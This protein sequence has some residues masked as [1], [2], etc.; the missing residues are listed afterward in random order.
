MYN[1]LTAVRALNDIAFVPKLGV[2]SI[3]GYTQQVFAY[4]AALEVL[5]TFTRTR[6]QEEGLK[7][8][9]EYDNLLF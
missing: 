4:S 7:D 2:S 5:D 1:C 9:Y 6:T 8:I 3:R